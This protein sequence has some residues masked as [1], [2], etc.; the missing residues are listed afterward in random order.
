MRPI[1]VLKR[2]G[3]FFEGPRWHDDRWYVSDFYRGAVF[4][5]SADGAEQEVVLV[6]TQ[7]SGVG[8]LPDGSMLVVS[9][10]DGRILRFH[11]DGGVHQ[12]AD[13]SS[14]A[15]GHLND[16]L[17]DSRGRAWVG[18]FGYDTRPERPVTSRLLR[19]DPDGAVAVAA[20]DLYFPNGMVNDA[21]R[22]DSGRGGDDREPVQRF[23]CCPG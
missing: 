4:A 16:M 18:C 17:V 13:L 22:T 9:M 7:P 19:V 5:V 11:P 14:M 15:I 23:H 8:W 6:P 20:E 3:G 21:G 10:L 1:H 12:H 2:G